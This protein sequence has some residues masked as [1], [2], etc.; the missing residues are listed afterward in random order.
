MD[1]A[2]LEQRQQVAALVNDDGDS[3]GEG[4]LPRQKPGHITPLGVRMDKGSGLLSREATESTLAEM[5]A[6][7]AGVRAWQPN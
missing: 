1:G 5:D 7:I 6:T 2:T 4:A 3:D